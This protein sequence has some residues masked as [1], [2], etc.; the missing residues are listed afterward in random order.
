MTR[1]Y[2]FLMCSSHVVRLSPHDALSRSQRIALESPRRCPTGLDR[3]HVSR[4]VRQIGLSEESR[5]T[6][7][8]RSVIVGHRATADATVS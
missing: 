8:H 7:L 3:P 6:L 2:V 5:T 1:P 4:R